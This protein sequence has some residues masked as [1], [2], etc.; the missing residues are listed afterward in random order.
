MNNEPLPDINILDNV[1]DYE[2]LRNLCK[3]YS[4]SDGIHL[5]DTFSVLHMNVR[6]LKNKFDAFQTFL[7]SSGVEWSII[8]I[9]ESWLKP[10]II[11]YFDLNK[12]NLFASCRVSGKGGGT[13][14][15]VHNS[16]DVKQIN[17]LSKVNDENTWVEIE[18]KHG[19]QIRKIIVGCIYR[20]PNS[21]PASFLEYM[22]K[23]MNIL[24]K[25]NKFIAL[26]G[27]FNYNLL[28]SSFD[29][30]VA[31]F[32]NLLSSYGFV[33][34]ICKP[35]RISANC[36]T[37][38]DNIF[39]NDHKYLQS[40][41]IIIE[42]LSDH[43][44]IF[45]SF[46]FSH[47]RC[48]NDKIKRV[49][50]FNKIDDLNNFLLNELQDF[51]T[52]N[53]PNEACDRLINTYTRGIDKFSKCIKPSRRKTPYK[54]WI[55]PNILCS[56]N[57]KNKLYKKYL[58]NKNEFN[59]NR[60]KQYKN[61]LTKIIREAKRLYFTKSF[62]ECRGDSKRTWKTLK[63]ALNVKSSHESLPSSF[64]D[65]SGKLFEGN[66]VPN[67]FNSFFTS[68][69][70]KLEQ[71]M[72]APDNSPLNYLRETTYPPFT[73]PL[74]TNSIQVKNI[75]TSLNPV[76]GGIDKISTKILI[77]TYEVC[78]DHLTY[79][80]NLCLHNST[81][82]DL[83][84][85]ALVKPIYK[86]GDKNKFTN[87]RPISLLPIFSK[88]LEKLIHSALISFLSETDILAKTQF[89]FRK[90][91]STYMPIS[92]IMD[93][94]TKGLENGEKVL[95]L[96]LD[97]KKAFDTVDS[98]IL[99]DKL[100]FIGIRGNLFKILVSYLANRKQR[101]QINNCLSE[102]N[103]INLGVPQGS[104]LG[105]LLFII[106]INDLPSVS[107]IS[108]FY[109]FADDTA[110][111]VKGNSLVDLQNKIN[112]IIPDI[113]RWFLSNRLSLN[114]SKTYYQLY[115]AA[116]NDDCINISINN[117]LIVRS[118]SLKYLGVILDENLKFDTHITKTAAKISRNIGVMAKIKYF[119][120]SKELLIL[121]NSFVLPY[122]NYCAVVWGC[123][124]MH[125]IKKI[126]LLQ[127][128]ALRI[129]D[130]KP[131]FFPCNELFVKYRVLKFPDLVVEQNIMILLAYLN[132]SLPQPV[133][134]LFQI[135][136]PLNTRATE[137]FRIPFTRLN[138]RL[139]TL[140]F[141]GPKSW[142]DVVM[143]VFNRLEEVPRNKM[144][145][146]KHIRNYLLSKYEY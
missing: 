138:F 61:V 74:D 93:N 144:T 20:P 88:V 126:V 53:D 28:N 112:L 80:F 105:P 54:P 102:L 34:T 86:A 29:N 46:N 50:D 117:N 129:I 136:E 131:Y 145:L 47:S 66:D 6:S 139:H 89:G 94:I 4:V 11:Q 96:Y 45:N 121:Y 109:L 114:A 17:S 119:L 65:E 128:R 33:S 49:F 110:I 22:S 71:N 103:E 125:R 113:T 39:V 1:T 108:D 63:E 76:G 77:G 91:H 55:T 16:L 79:F 24:E 15:Y 21:C 30:N 90:K 43:L 59:E 8:C 67:G 122:I 115:S 25:E 73:E 135:N 111:I 132:G 57:Y 60:Y 98:K 12:Y 137:H 106:Y 146:K 143:K 87:Y 104:I 64:F 97:L 13:A 27:D 5:G 14:I 116:S 142:N 3:Y 44:P 68:V 41:G 2:N 83:L 123:N 84:K 140:S 133:A 130:N 72:P 18:L 7:T 120:S 38:L 51:Q 82:P 42:D 52:L 75:I 48:D 10:D 56:I 26:T 127:K 100:H 36:S 85:I 95:G 134:N 37:L 78:L 92:L 58:R 35:T 124:Y 118:P 101:V 81:F 107:D 32:S 62:H 70:L 19:I 9:T 23:I 40:S 141:M 31:S 99:L 69:A